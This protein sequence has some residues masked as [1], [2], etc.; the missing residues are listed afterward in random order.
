[1]GRPYLAPPGLPKDRADTLRQA[2]LDTMQDKEFL[3]EA[4]TAQLEIKPVTGPDIEKL[5]HEVY[6]TPAA[7]PPRRRRCSTRSE[8]CRMG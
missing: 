1:M 4:D 6:Q 8:Q 3:A 2:F 7:S 5:V